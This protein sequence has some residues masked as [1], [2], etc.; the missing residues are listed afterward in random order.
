MYEQKET[1]ERPDIWIIRGDYNILA[2]ITESID[3]CKRELL[4]V[5][6]PALN[7]VVDL[8]IPALTNVKAAGVNVRIL[9]SGEINE[10]SIAKINS[11]AELRLKENMFGG[12]VIVDANE[13]ILL[14]GRSSENRES[15]AIWSDHAGL[16]SFAKNYFEFLWTEA[17]LPLKVSRP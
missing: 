8:V 4:V 13:V 2:K 14:L 9:M 17:G 10:R 11:L 7:S 6:P 16:A 5:I 15:L 3:R 12:G 1:Q